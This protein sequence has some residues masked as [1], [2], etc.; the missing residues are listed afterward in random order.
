LIIVGLIIVRAFP[1]DAP[2]TK[3]S[4]EDK[5][6]SWWEEPEVEKVAAEKSKEVVAIRPQEKL[7]DTEKAEETKEKTEDDWLPDSPW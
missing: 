3:W 2:P 6:K 1:P 7:P 4:E 5:E